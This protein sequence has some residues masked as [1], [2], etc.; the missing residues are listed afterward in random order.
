[1][2][3]KITLH[4]GD[5]AEVLKQYPDN[6]FDSI[7]TDPPYGIEF[8]GKEWDKNTGAIEVW[9]EC[10]RVLKPGGHILAFSAARTYHR[11]ATNLEDI[12]FEIRDQIMW[13]YGSGFPKGQDM[14]KLIE[15]REGKR[16]QWGG[17]DVTPGLENRG[18]AVCKKCGK[19]NPDLKT[20]KGCHIGE[21]DCPLEQSLTPADNEYAGWK[22]GL[23]PAHEPIVM[24]RKPFKGSTVDNVLKN[25]VGAINIDDTRVGD[26]EVTIKQYSDAHYVT[27]GDSK[28]NNAEHTVRT[29]I[30]RYP[31]NV[32]GEIEGE[33]QKYF[34]K[35]E[36]TEEEVHNPI[37]MA[38]K[39]FKGSTVD[40]VIEYG[41]GAINIDD[42]RVEVTDT[43]TFA[44]NSIGYKTV[45]EDKRSGDNIYG[46]KKQDAD[47]PIQ[48]PQG[49]YPSNVIMSE[50]EGKV[51]DDKT[52]IIKSVGGKRNKEDGEYK[53]TG[54]K[55]K[56]QAGA[57]YNPYV[58]EPLKGASKY[59][60]QPQLTEEEVHEPIVMARK[61]F[62]GSTVDNVIKHGTGAINIDDTRVG[63]HIW[64]YTP[65]G[66]S[67]ESGK[68]L[69]FG[70]GREGI[71]VAFKE[72]RVGRYPSNV[73]MSEEDKEYS[74]YYY[75]PKVSR[76]E[77]N[78]GCDDLKEKHIGQDTDDQTSKYG[79]YYCNDCGKQIVDHVDHSK[80][81]SSKGKEWRQTLHLAN[82]HPTVKPVALMKYLVTLVT[83][84][85]GKV[86]DPFNGSGS[87]GM[88][89]KEFGGE[90]VG[91]D[92]N[93]DYIEIANRRITAW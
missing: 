11:L 46:F 16:K 24:A 56:N 23:K 58:N 52:G 34:Y 55:I 45:P 53:A 74:K 22:T 60:F 85:G 18:T 21:E 26:E 19:G 40:N 66:Y 35:P 41:T 14:G 61:P 82:N 49:R 63:N 29:S 6:H 78:I 75:C 15:K 37:V 36:L 80:C 62:K 5:S 48:T 68:S 42:T 54:Y 32:I 12:G 44:N 89:V 43:E 9:Q 4:S 13:I 3:D 64:E 67:K 77:R 73:I 51:L 84:K 8:L 33:E 93:P 17:Y 72:E 39:P 57:D 87:T 50:E 30:G 81:D 47:E 83:P 71:E 31:S 28:M 69:Q 76:K 20:W 25:G 65:E 79:K 86:L 59:F 70:K 1:M 91:I 10:L 2:A 38:R 90:Y 92:L 88:A 7:V 27:P